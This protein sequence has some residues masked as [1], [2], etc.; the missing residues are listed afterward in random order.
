LRRSAAEANVVCSRIERIHGKA[1]GLGGTHQIDISKHGLTR[2]RLTRG[3]GGRG[4][5]TDLPVAI[6][7]L[8]T[9]TPAE[10]L[11]DACNAI[12]VAFEQEKRMVEPVDPLTRSIIAGLA[13]DTTGRREI[14]AARRE[15]NHG[16]VV[17]DEAETNRLRE[18]Q[19]QA[20]AV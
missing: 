9:T 2:F 14:A 13:T 7:T 19:E 18:R 11:R 12:D 1:M 16:V 6:E 15:L 10:V 5:C 3:D 20:A 17:E 8:A 4:V